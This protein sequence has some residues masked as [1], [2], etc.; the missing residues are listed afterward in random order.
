VEASKSNMADGVEKRIN[1]KSLQ[2]HTRERFYHFLKLVEKNS[3]QQN[4]NSTSEGSEDEIGETKLSPENKK[5]RLRSDTKD[6]I[7]ELSERNKQL[8]KGKNKK[9]KRAYQDRKDDKNTYIDCDSDIDSVECKETYWFEN[10][11]VFIPA[12]QRITP[13]EYVVK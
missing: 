9:Q 4:E 7:S 13:L 8:S 3:L 6:N 1:L 2:K 12:N 11:V 5:R 10:E